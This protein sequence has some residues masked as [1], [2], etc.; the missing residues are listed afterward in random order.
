MNP[1][2]GFLAEQEFVLEALKNSFRV[3][4][5]LFQQEVYDFVLD[6]KGKLNRIQVKATGEF[7][8]KQQRYSLTVRKKDGTIYDKSEIDFIVAIIPN[9]IYYIIPVEE[10]TSGNLRIYNRNTRKLSNSDTGKFD[11]FLNSWD[12]LK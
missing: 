8:I 6:Y 12:L 9:N 3:S 4:Q 5:P 1:H 10:L 7:D 11:K 2:K